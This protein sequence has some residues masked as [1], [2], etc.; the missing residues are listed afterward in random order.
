MILDIEK[1]TNELQERI[2]HCQTVAE[3]LKSNSAF[4]LAVQDFKKNVELADS[5]WHFIDY[6]APS[7]EGR[8]SGKDLLNQ[9]KYNKLAGLALINLVENYELEI[10]T[11]LKTLAEM[12]ERQDA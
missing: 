4:Q 9:L 6:D 10:Q 3:G 11:H 2:H 7:K 12:Q 8:P 1:Y 5:N